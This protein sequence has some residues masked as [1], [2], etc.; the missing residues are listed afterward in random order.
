[1]SKINKQRPQ[2]ALILTGGGARAAYQ[3]GILKALTTILPRNHKSPFRIIC[4]TSAGSINATQLACYASC[5]HL[6]VKK[7]EWAWK[8]F[9]TSQVYHSDLRRVFSHLLSGI[10]SNFQANYSKVKPASLFNNAPLSDLLHRL[11]DLERINRNLNRNHLDAL[12]ITASSYSDGDSISFFQAINKPEWRRAK[13][14]GV[15]TKISIEHLL[16]SSAIPMIFPSTKLKRQYFG[17]GSIH[18]LSPLSPAIRLGAEKIFIIGV[19]QPNEDKFYGQ[20][21]HHPSIAYLSGHLL[22]TIFADTLSA[23]IERMER[24]NQTLNLIPNHQDTTPFRH[25]SSMIINP[26][27]DFDPIAHQFYFDIP[28]AI[29][30]LLNCIGINEHTESSLVSYLLFEH[31]YIKQLIDLGFEDGINKLADIRE[32]LEL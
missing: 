17:D 29:R 15:S 6:G 3:V 5:Y 16:A 14:R 24:I 11:I 30:L 26:S 20:S 28:W 31:Q 10:L 12:C 32:F 22:D 27:H 25:V 13:R 4:G 2:T 7:L 9:N 19:D 21:S 23:D 18:Q 1:M 8:N